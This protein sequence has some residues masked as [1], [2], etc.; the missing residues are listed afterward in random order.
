MCY[1]VFLPVARPSWE[2]KPSWDLSPA[3]AGDGEIAGGRFLGW[4]KSF[5][6]RLR[7]VV[8]APSSELPSGSEVHQAYPSRCCCVEVAGAT[9]P[10]GRA[11]QSSWAARRPLGPRLKRPGS[12]HRSGREPPAPRGAAVNGSAGALRRGGAAAEARPAAPSQRS[13]ESSRGL[14]GERFE[15]GEGGLGRVREG[16]PA[17]RWGEEGPLCRA[18]RSAQR[19]RRSVPAPPVLGPSPAGARQLGA[20]RSEESGACRERAGGRG[21]YEDRWIPRARWGARRGRGAGQPPRR[22]GG[23]AGGRLGRGAVPPGRP[24]SRP[25]ARHRH[26]VCGGLRL[27][28][29]RWRPR[30]CGTWC[31]GSGVWL[32]PYSTRAVENRGV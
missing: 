28:R 20:R 26:F 27:W 11:A 29:S 7:R 8:P 32:G 24:G 30:V 25:P 4:L 14:R 3:S 2:D 5:K 18:E 1:P 19:R 17:G 16:Q 9:V 21:G 6:A 12:G 31:G 22:A 10:A 23:R 13:R 15:K